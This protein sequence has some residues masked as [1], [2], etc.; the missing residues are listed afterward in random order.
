VLHLHGSWTPSGTVTPPRPRAACATASPLWEGIFPSIQPEPPLEQHKAIPSHCRWPPDHCKAMSVGRVCRPDIMKVLPKNVMESRQFDC[1]RVLN[2]C[3]CMQPLSL[4]CVLALR[5]W[6][7]HY[8]RSKEVLFMELT[9]RCALCK[10]QK[11][12]TSGV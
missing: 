1:Y 11:V 3:Q 2:I 12:M 8:V 4:F 5:V 10:F 6:E 7:L 9:I